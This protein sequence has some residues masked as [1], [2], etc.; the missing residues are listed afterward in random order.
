MFEL[1]PFV[2]DCDNVRVVLSKSPMKN[3]NVGTAHV[4]HSILFKLNKVGLAW[5]D[6]VCT[7][8]TAP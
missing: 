1:F 2:C 8:G 3:A 7:N 6:G 4:M 5:R